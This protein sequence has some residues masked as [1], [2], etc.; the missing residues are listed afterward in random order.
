[1]YM[2]QIGVPLIPYWEKS[3]RYQCVKPEAWAAK[4]FRKSEINGKMCW[5]VAQIQNILV[6]KRY[7]ERAICGALG[8][9]VGW[10]RFGVICYWNEGIWLERVKSTQLTLYGPHSMPLA[11]KYASW[12]LA[13]YKK[14][15]ISLIIRWT[16][17]E[18]NPGW[19]DLFDM[20]YL[21]KEIISVDHWS[22][23]HEISL[24]S[25]LKSKVHTTQTASPQ[26]ISTISVCCCQNWNAN[27]YRN[28]DSYSNHRR[29]QGNYAFTILW[30][31]MKNGSCMEQELL[32]LDISAQW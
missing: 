26:Q 19:W 28:L 4:S 8:V 25:I 3:T 15:S 31:H 10:S 32:E 17:G 27:S 7:R 24:F 9:L 13:Y 11:A 16:R 2:C 22:V 5:I 18:D 20:L 30:Q 1:M 14:N 23:W 21:A 6:K 29:T 12:L